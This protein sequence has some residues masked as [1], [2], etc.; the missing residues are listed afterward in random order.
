MS[1]NKAMTLQDLRV[2]YDLSIYNC[3]HF[4]P[5]TQLIYEDL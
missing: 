2:L 3:V 5:Y 4:G 1:G